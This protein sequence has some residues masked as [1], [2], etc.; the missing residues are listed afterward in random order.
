MLRVRHVGVAVKLKLKRR[1]EVLQREASR[2]NRKKIRRSV[3]KDLFNLISSSSSFNML[4]RTQNRSE[5][6]RDLRALAA[7]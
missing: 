4:K 3:D 5:S 7:Y 1:N 6:L 2:Y